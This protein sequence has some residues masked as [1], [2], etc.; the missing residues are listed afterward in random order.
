MSLTTRRSFIATTALGLTGLTFSKPVTGADSVTESTMPIVI[1]TWKH[2]IPANEAAWEVLS[3][4]GY[5][6]DAVEAGVKVAESDPG[7]MTVGYGG[8]PDASG[9]VTLD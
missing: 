8:F 9:E 5:A 1:S 7:V 2:G 3:A 4:G 6:L